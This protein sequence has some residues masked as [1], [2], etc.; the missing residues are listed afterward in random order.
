MP[1]VYV[2]P[3]KKSRYSGGGAYKKSTARPRK[4][5]RGPGAYTIDDGPWATRGD[6]VG[7]TIGS[8]FG[9]TAA[10]I[11]GWLG[12]NAFHYPAKWLGSGS[13]RRKRKA[14]GNGSY[15]IEDVPAGRM[16]PEIPRFEKSGDDD[17]IV[18]SHREYIGDIFTSSSSN[19]FSV[20]EYK[21]NPGDPVT[22]PWLSTVA[23]CSYQQFKLLGCIFEFI[24][25]SSDALNSTNT[26]LGAV[27]ACVNYDANDPAFTSRMQ[28][29]NT[30]WA[31][32][33]KPSQNMSIGVECAPRMTAMQGMLYVSQNGVLPADADPKTY[34]LGKMSIATTGFQG[35]SINIGSLYVTYK[36]KLFKPIMLPPLSNANR[37][38]YCRS[39]VTSAIPFGTTA[40]STPSAS[41]DTLGLTFTN[42]TVTIPKA[43]LQNGQRFI[44]IAEWNH[45]SGATTN[46]TASYSSGATRFLAWGNTA[47]QSVA[48]APIQTGT[49]T[50]TMMS[51]FF[52][53]NN[54][55]V[56]CVITW[57]SATFPSNCGLN[58]TLWQVCGMPSTRLGSITA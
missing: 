23:Q 54:D 21:I 51:E 41:C 34:Y 15:M 57:A 12:R 37:A 5:A 29:E 27:V 47:S 6:I 26:A 31:N 2:P 58:F 4:T 46:P 8:A 42:T 28:M 32:C 1:L 39:G 52:E 43:R 50:R 48:Y 18:I 7:R 19:T 49:S 20:N 10:A 56:D 35:T 9:P 16:A 3:R 45:D 40:V 22:F 44:Y 24:S 38:L 14:G 36:V 25:T 17:A 11:G 13:Y 30:S 55:N 53:I 33:C